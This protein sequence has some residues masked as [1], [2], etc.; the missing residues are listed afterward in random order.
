M[1]VFCSSGNVPARRTTARRALAS[2]V[3]AAFALS[4]L[5]QTSTAIKPTN[6]AKRMPSG[7]SIPA[8][9][10]FKARARSF[11]ASVITTQ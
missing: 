9:T 3:T 8:E 2:E 1:R 5:P 7:D 4:K 11:T 6:R 10:A